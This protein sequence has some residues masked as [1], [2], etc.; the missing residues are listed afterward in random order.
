ML[1]DNPRKLVYI[2][3]GWKKLNIYKQTNSQKIILQ[4]YVF[5]W[6]CIVSVLVLITENLIACTKTKEGDTNKKKNLI[7]T[8]IQRS[9]KT[10]TKVGSGR[11]YCDHLKN[12]VHSLR[13]KYLYDGGKLHVLSGEPWLISTDRGPTPTL[14]RGAH[15]IIFI[16]TFFRSNVFLTRPGFSFHDR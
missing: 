16:A 14:H 3:W 9:I 6:T 13:L 11:W 1:S 5:F 2:L 7:E 12:A 4:I 15:R 8:R 10:E